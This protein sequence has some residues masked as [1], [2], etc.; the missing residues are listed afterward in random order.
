MNRTFVGLAIFLSTAA[1]QSLPTTGEDVPGM[2]V[3]DRLIPA[4]LRKYK[5]PG[6]SVA[7]MREGRLVF[8][9][10]YGY[11]DVE[12]QTP[13]QPDSLFRIGSVT[14]PLTAVAVLKLAEAGRL[15]LDARVL[16]VLSGV[17]PPPGQSVHFDFRQVTVRQLLQHAGG[18]DRARSGDPMFQNAAVTGA[19]G[20]ASPAGCADVI[21]WMLPRALDFT[22]GQRYAY[23]NFGYCL[24][25]RVIEQ[26]SGQ[27]YETYIKENVLLP[28]GIGRMAIGASALAGRREGE[29]RYY[30]YEGEPLVPAVLPGMAAQVPAMYGGWDLRTMDAHGGWVASAVDLLRFVKA[31][32]TGETALKRASVAQ[33]TA[34]PA[35]PVAAANATTFYGMGWMVR[36]GVNEGNWWHNGSMAGTAALLVRAGQ[37]RSAWAILLNSRDREGTAIFTEM[38][39]IMWSAINQSAVPSHDLFARYPS[40][41][42]LVASV[43]ALEFAPPYEAKT[44]ALTGPA[45]PRD[46]SVTVPEAAWIRAQVRGIQT[47]ATITVSVNPEGLEEGEYKETLQVATTG[48]NRTVLPIAVTLRVTGVPVITAIRNAASQIEGPVAAGSLVE[49]TGANLEAAEIRVGGVVVPLMDGRFVVPVELAP[50]A[51]AR[52]TAALPDGRSGSR[53]IAVESTAPGLSSAVREGDV[54]TL[55]GTGWRNQMDLAAYAVHAGETPLEVLAVRPDPERPGIDLLEARWPAELPLDLALVLTVDGRASNAVKLDQ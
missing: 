32:E 49:I 41:P 30:P 27:P 5:I 15:N 11:A 22:P 38:D 28:M 19:L 40:V 23:S 8:A 48:A 14:K 16:D 51:P 45:G 42:D 2:A 44:I 3:Y 17:A 35:A 55:T 36:P 21:R 29:V 26:A 52:F 50:G 7:V 43:A 31:L 9:R 53:D 54:L 6:A 33:M 37:N 4:F 25:G 46:F 39:Q 47:P 1:A 18:W 20:V 24:L 12:A 10:G 34:R 13:V